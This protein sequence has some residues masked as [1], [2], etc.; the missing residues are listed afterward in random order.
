M[1]DEKSDSI[2]AKL[3]MTSVFTFDHRYG[4]GAVGAHAVAVAADYVE[5]PENFDPSKHLDKM[6]VEERESSALAAASDEKKKN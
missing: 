4:D 6:S 5:D 1:Y 3:I 2:I